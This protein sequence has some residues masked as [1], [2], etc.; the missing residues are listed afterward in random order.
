[1]EDD[2]TGVRSDTVKW[3]SLSSWKPEDQ[4]KTKQIFGKLWKNVFKKL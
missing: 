3:S 1:M 2:I 4:E